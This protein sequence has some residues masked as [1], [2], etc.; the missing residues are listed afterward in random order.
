MQIL[1]FKHQW[2]PLLPYKF[3][4]TAVMTFENSAGIL[5]VSNF[6]CVFHGLSFGGLVCQIRAP[7]GCFETLILLNMHP[8]DMGSSGKRV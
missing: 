6:N 8:V 7:A 1:R 5:I 2:L 3:H 4:I